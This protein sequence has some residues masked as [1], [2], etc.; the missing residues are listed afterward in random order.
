MS[1]GISRERVRLSCGKKFYKKKRGSLNRE[2]TPRVWRFKGG[3]YEKMEVSLVSYCA[4]GA[5]LL[6]R[7]KGRVERGGGGG[8]R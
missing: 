4:S 3:S 1:V 6:R 2:A 7:W 5:G 8:K